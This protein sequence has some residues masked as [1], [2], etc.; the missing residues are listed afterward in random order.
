MDRLSNQCLH[1]L[2]VNPT[3]Q[4]TVESTVGPSVRQT[5]RYVLKPCKCAIPLVGKLPV[6]TGRKP[7]IGISRRAVLS[8]DVGLLV[9]TVAPSVGSW[10]Y[11][12]TIYNF[13]NIRSRPQ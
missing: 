2:T 1:N 8:A 13:K 6:I 10:G 9:L 4:P 3:V 5:V 7:E 12:L 11:L